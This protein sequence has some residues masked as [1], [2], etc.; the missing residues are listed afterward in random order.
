MIARGWPGV[1]PSDKAERYA[2]YLA[3]SDL[4]VRAYRAIRGNRGVTLL[5]RSDG[6]RS[7]FLLISLWE[8]EDAIREYTGPDIDRAQYFPVDLECLVDPE[9]NVTHYEVLVADGGAA[10]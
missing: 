6:R 9:P 1:V 10:K 8:S 2:T 7:H 5:R 3:D 4:G